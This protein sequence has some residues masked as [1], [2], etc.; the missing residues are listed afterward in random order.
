LLQNVVPCTSSGHPKNE[1]KIKQKRAKEKKK[2]K[3]IRRAETPM[4]YCEEEAVSGEPTPIIHYSSSL[5]AR[6]RTQRM[7]CA[8]RRLIPTNLSRP[9]TNPIIF[10]GSHL[11]SFFLSLLPS[12]LPTKKK[13]ENQKEIDKV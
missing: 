3:E 11:I 5:T 12:L 1:K 4:T 13:I 8:R 9:R 2:G 7:H 6:R 10:T